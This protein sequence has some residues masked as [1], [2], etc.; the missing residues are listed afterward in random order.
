[1][2]NPD[3]P[4]ILAGLVRPLVWSLPIPKQNSTEHLSVCGR[5]KVIEWYDGS[6]HVLSFHRFGRPTRIDADTSAAEGFAKLQAAA[7]ADHA[8]HVLAAIDAD[9]LRAMV[10]ALWQISKESMGE[11]GCY[12]TNR[13]NIR[14][15]IDALAGLVEKEKGE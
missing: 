5:Y 13:V 14:R 15:A 2:T 8:A 12:Y 3:N 1:M 11:D 9:K 10:Y 6:G 7:N 4:D